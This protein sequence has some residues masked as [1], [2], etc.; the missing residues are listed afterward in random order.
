MKIG[1]LKSEGDPRCPVTLK[2]LKNYGVSVL[3]E[4]GL[5]D[6]VGE[7]YTLGD[8]VVY[9]ER[10]KIIEKCDI[11]FSTSPLKGDELPALKK[12][13]TLI[14][15]YNEFRP[16]HTVYDGDFPISA[17]SMDMIPRTTLAQAM[18]VLSSMASLAGYNAIL[19]AALRL[20]RYFPMMMTAAGTIKPSTV[21]VLGAG[22]AGLQAIATAR[23]LGARVEAF[24]VRKAVKEEVESLGAKFVEVEGSVD[25]KAAGGYAVEQTEE[26]QRR[27]KEKIHERVKNADVVVA[28]AQIRGRQAPVLVTRE[29]V[30]DMKF[31][32][33]I[34]D[35]AS[36][37]G[38]NCEVTRDKETYI[39][40]G[41]T[42]IGDSDLAFHS[43]MDASELLANNVYNYLSL[44]IK[45]GK[46]FIDMKNEI[47]SS[48]IMYP[49]SN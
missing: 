8:A 36:S 26:Y 39:Y 19:L 20:P 3:L 31:G 40:K 10:N 2:T 48:S 6:T 23:R 42:I 13:A 11:I 49:K 22:V 21:L 25:D 47:I 24:D 18:D 14:S 32:S 44:F 29:M 28:T 38:G 27:Q 30:E 4:A 5:S 9:T 46:L 12:G 15:F 45:E 43:V 35:L 16:D 7:N 34:I 33:V 37:T 17:F 41:V 1:F